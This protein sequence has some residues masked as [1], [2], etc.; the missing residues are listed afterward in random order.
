VARVG[1]NRSGLRLDSLI[2]GSGAM[3]D[4]LSEPRGRLQIDVGKGVMSKFKIGDMVTYRPESAHSRNA[5]RP[6]AYK[7]IA[8][9]PSE[10]RRFVSDQEHV[11]GSPARVADETEL[12]KV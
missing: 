9:M 7:V 3:K 10:G 12:T 5:A 2:R 6:A 4:L 8:V 1:S 11:R